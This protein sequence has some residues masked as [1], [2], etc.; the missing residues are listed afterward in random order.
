MYVC[1]RA[2]A[3]QPLS[4]KPAGRAFRQISRY[5]FFAVSL[6]TPPV[7]RFKVEQ[8]AI[9]IIITIIYD[10]RALATRQNRPAATAAMD[11]T[12]RPTKPSD[13]VFKNNRH[14][15]RVKIVRDK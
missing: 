12:P 6:E 2:C 8:R 10:T 13:R 14:D 11:G 1:I 7:S 5:F 3:R 9:I 15:N 4:R